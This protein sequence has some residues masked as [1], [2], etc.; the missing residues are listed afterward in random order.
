MHISN[1]LIALLVSIHILKD[2]RGLKIYMHF[3]DPINQWSHTIINIPTVNVS[4]KIGIIA[5]H[6]QN[7]SFV[8]TRNGNDRS[9]ICNNRFAFVVRYQVLSTLLNK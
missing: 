8:A 5:D 3:I 1:H 2:R 7:I 4:A 9:E 6:W